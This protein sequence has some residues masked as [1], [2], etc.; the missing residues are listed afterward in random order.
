MSYIYIFMSYYLYHNHI[1]LYYYIL[2]LFIYTF[3][4]CYRSCNTS[5]IV[6]NF[7]FIL[8]I[9][10]I[11]HKKKHGFKI[12]PIRSSTCHNFGSIN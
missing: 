6:Y 5:S 3:I 1:Y 2:I 7:N 8:I 11:L 4:Q 9:V 12:E 10:Q